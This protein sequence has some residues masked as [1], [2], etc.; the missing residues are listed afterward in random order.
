[1]RQ[2]CLREIQ[3]FS[4]LP[5]RKTPL[6]FEPT[7]SEGVGMLSQH[8]CDEGKMICDTEK[9]LKIHNTQLILK[10]ALC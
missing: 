4:E 3:A 9:L 8:N 10:E 1:M 2:H 5:L 6:E 7:V